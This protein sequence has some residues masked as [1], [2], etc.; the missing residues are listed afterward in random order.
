MNVDLPHNTWILD[1][2]PGPY[3]HSETSQDSSQSVANVIK[4]LDDLPMPLP[5]RA[6]VV[7]KLTGNGISL[8]IAQWLSTSLKQSKHGEGVEWV[9]DL[10]VAKQLFNN[11]VELDMRPF[12]RTYKGDSVIHFVRA[13]RSEKWSPDVL[14]FFDEVVNLQQ[15]QA[16]G[17]HKNIQ[18]HLM[19]A[20]GHWLHSEDLAGLLNIINSKNVVP[21]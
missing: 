11:F 13:G 17:S 1:S 7:K 2:L 19:P 21:S 16:N 8:T 5:S 4:A 18:L 9:F 3:T 20:A 14:K 15:W 10:K 6:E 12:L